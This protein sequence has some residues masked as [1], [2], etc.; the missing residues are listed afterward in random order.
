MTDLFVNRRTSLKGEFNN[1]MPE[2]PASGLI[3]DSTLKQLA[4]HSQQGLEEEVPKLFDQLV[5]QMTALDDQ[6]LVKVCMINWTL[7]VK[8][9]I[10]QK[11]FSYKLLLR[12]GE[13]TP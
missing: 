12:F 2:A 7:P 1:I 5:Q 3:V 9:I 8:P 13:K 6:E 4:K 11:Y 10:Y